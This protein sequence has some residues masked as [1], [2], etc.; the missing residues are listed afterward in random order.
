MAKMGPIPPSR[1]I[2]L[3]VVLCVVLVASVGVAAMVS[4]VIERQTG[5][6]LR[7]P[8]AI[9][10]L[11]VRLPDGWDID[12]ESS[13]AGTAIRAHS[14]A[15][16]DPVRSLRIL[17]VSNPFSLACEKIF[18]SS[19]WLPQDYFVGAGE[20]KIIN[21]YTF[22]IAGHTAMLQEGLRVAR[23]RPGEAVFHEIFICVSLP[24]RKEAL[25]MELQAVR[26]V[27]DMYDRSDRLLLRRI[28]ESIELIAPPLNPV[29]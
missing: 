9:G 10:T 21:G 4:A 19:S 14:P 13:R 12:A 2:W 17:H 6:T 24:A 15:D 25:M 20:G 28:A 18:E 16:A 26:T 27:D 1:R 3:Q 8:E 11:R 5:V 23:E 22:E 29:Q 7:S